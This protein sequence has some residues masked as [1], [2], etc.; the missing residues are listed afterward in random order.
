MPEKGGISPR[1]IQSWTC[2]EIYELEHHFPLPGYFAGGFDQ[3]KLD[4]LIV[5]LAPAHVAILLD[6]PAFVMCCLWAKF[7]IDVLY[8]SNALCSQPCHM[9]PWHLPQTM[10]RIIL[11]PPQNLGSI[12]NLWGLCL[13]IT[14]MQ[15]MVLVYSPTW[16]GDVVRANVGK[17][18]STMEHMGNAYIAL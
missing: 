3:T 5:S 10:W 7:I 16:L 18:S 13:R 12:L 6:N 9:E 17:Y 2:D 14:H 15:P 11:Q 8:V 4:R 1:N